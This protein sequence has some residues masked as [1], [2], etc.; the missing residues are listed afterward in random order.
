ML[1]YIVGGIIAPVAEEIFSGVVYGYVKGRL[2]VFRPVGG[3]GGAIG[4]HR[5]ICVCP[6][7]RLRHSPA[8]ACGGI[9][10]CLSY[11]IEKSLITPMIIHSTGNMALFT[12]SFF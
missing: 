10:F 9:V 7:D 1:L 4:Q 8:P 2:A 5:P 11:E 3:A 6:S 12:L